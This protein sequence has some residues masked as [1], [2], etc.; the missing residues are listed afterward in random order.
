VL[1]CPF[2]GVTP[3]KGNG[4]QA[5]VHAYALADLVRD[6]TDQIEV[7]P[8]HTLEGLMVKRRVVDYCYGGRSGRPAQEVMLVGPGAY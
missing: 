5:S 3:N 8:A 6:V 4:T 7:L 2:Y 1:F